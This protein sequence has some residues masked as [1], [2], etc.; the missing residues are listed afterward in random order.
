MSCTSFNE[1]ACL[2]HAAR[3]VNH[4]EKLVGREEVPN[5]ADLT[6]TPKEPPEFWALKKRFLA[7]Q[8][9]ADLGKGER[10]RVSLPK[11]DRSTSGCLSSGASRFTRSQ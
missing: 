10:D 6:F 7:G 2:P 11:N 5:A 1:Q 4:Q 3:T 8:T 9:V